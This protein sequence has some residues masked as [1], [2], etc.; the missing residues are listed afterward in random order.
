MRRLDDQA[1]IAH[2]H[3]D[4]DHKVL[5]IAGKGELSINFYQFTNEAPFIE[6]L[7]S[8]KSKEPQKGFSMLP[9]RSVN[10]MESEV[11][12][13]VRMTSK[14]VE[15]VK[16][17]VPR[18][19]GGFSAELYPAWRSTTAAHDFASYAEG[20]NKDPLRE[21]VAPEASNTGA[22]KA[23]FLKKVTGVDAPAP[24]V[25]ETKSDNSAALLAAK[26]AEIGEL[27]AQVA[28]L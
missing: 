26:D 12:R 20:N 13:G 27:K 7:S 25:E 10:V 16:F 9:K 17:K 4:E 19:T 14:T 23:S 15:Y 22:K 18:K 5:Y 28:A 8:F 6:P 2:L 24:K 1:G 11:M 21:E 3:F